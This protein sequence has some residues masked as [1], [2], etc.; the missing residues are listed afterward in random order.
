MKGYPINLVGLESQ[1]CVVIGGGEVAERKITGLISAGAQP[2]VISSEP[3]PGLAELLEKGQIDHIDREYRP[4]DLEGAF[5]VIVATDDLELNRQ[6]WEEACLQNTLVNVV[7]AP[8]LCNFHVPSVVKRGDFT[9]SISTGGAAP[10]LAVRT[11]QELETQFGHEY[12][13]LTAW[14]AAIRPAMLEAFPDFKERK[15][16]WY[17][18]VDSPVLTFLAQGQILEARAWIGR[19]LGPYVAGFLPDSIERT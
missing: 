2:I 11:R 15:T 6:I 7:D 3:A 13:I 5:L 10:A 8:H 16:H 4:G 9:V 19:V 12:T 18:L 1:R 17:A 14:C